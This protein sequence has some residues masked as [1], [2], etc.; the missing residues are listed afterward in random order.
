M[1]PNGNAGARRNSNFPNGYGTP[2]Q[3]PSHT[4]ARTFIASKVSASISLARE[5]RDQ[6][7]TG[8]VGSPD[9][10]ANA[11]VTVLHGPAAN[12]MR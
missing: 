12:A 1:P 2:H 9:A 7:V 10:I 5:R 3:L 6:S 8:T 4:S 11:W